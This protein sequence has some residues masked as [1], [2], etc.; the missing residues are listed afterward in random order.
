[1]WPFIRKIKKIELSMGRVL[2]VGDTVRVIDD[3]QVY[4]NYSQMAR[5]L[6][7]INQLRWVY[8]GF[9]NHSHD[10]TIIAI[11]NHVLEDKFDNGM[12]AIAI[13]DKVTKQVY[14]ISEYGI[15]NTCCN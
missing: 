6:S 11:F 7:R 4:I 3:D 10:F 5:K 13:Q 8:K 1:M 9:P 15:T 2:A 12:N 14:L